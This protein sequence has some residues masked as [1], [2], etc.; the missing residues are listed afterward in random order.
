MGRELWIAIGFVLFIGACI[1]V[2]TWPILKDIVLSPLRRYEWD[3]E[4]S[5]GK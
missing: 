5:D 1:K 4:D 3:E 2:L